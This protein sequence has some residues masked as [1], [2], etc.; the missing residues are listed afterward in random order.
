MSLE[1][2]EFNNLQSSGSDSENEEFLNKDYKEINAE[3]DSDNSEDL[4]NENKESQL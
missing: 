2:E 4:D 3:E 1:N